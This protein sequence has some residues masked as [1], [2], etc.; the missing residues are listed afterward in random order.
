MQDTCSTVPVHWTISSLSNSKCVQTNN[1]KTEKLSWYSDP[2]TCRSTE[3]LCLLS[4]QKKEMFLVSKN[5]D[6]PLSQPSLRF[7]ECSTLPDLKQSRPEADHLPSCNVE[8]K[9][10]VKL[11]HRYSIRLHAVHVDI[12]SF[13]KRDRM[14]IS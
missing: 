6:R 10:L 9:N 5:P 14:A 1:L 7:G 4:Y 13:S 8:V 11:C 2:A 12:L 3:E